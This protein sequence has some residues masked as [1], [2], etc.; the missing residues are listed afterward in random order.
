MNRMKRQMDMTLKGKLPRSVGA[1]Y[2]TGEE[3]RNSSR[4]TEEAKPK[5]KQCPVVDVTGEG[6][7]VQCWER[8]KAGGEGDDRG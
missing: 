5:R 3:W 6:I 1:Q 2:V 4:K 7:K 8:L